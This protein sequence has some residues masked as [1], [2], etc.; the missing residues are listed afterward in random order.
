MIQEITIKTTFKNLQEVLSLCTNQ[1]YALALLEDTLEDY[2]NLFNKEGDDVTTAVKNFSFVTTQGTVIKAICKGV[3]YKK[4][5][6][7][8]TCFVALSKKYKDVQEY[9]R[10]NG[11]NYDNI[12]IDKDGTTIISFEYNIHLLRINEI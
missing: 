7:L 11:K 5:I 9:E 12:Q 8:T 4:A 2:K 10:E 6:T 1:E 3:D